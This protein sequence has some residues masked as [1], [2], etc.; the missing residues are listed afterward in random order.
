MVLSW[1]GSRRWFVEDGGVVCAS[2]RQRMGSWSDDMNVVV[3][4][5]VRLFKIAD[6]PKVDPC[7]SHLQLVATRRE[8]EV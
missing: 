3:L 2:E 7:T 8:R 5:L 1:I 6:L 4:E